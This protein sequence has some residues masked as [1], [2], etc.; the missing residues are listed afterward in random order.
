MG[1]HYYWITAAVLALDLLTKW[2]VETRMEL[3]D[4]IE[5]VEGYLRLTFVRNPGVAFGIFADFQSAWKPYVFAA[6]AVLA[7]VAIFLYSR[8]MSPERRLLQVALSMTMGGILGNF[9]DRLR[10]G[11][12]VDFVEFHIHNS[13]SWPTFNVADSAISV[14]ICLLLIDTLRHP[15]GAKS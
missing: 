1:K 8:H 3:F 9:L 10:H 2:L 13:F 12:V 14:G 5:I 4:S 15:D 6:M 11:S 7:V